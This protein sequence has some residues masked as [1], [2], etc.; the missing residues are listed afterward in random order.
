MANNA[1]IKVSEFKLKYD[2]H[3]KSGDSVYFKEEDY[4]TPTKGGWHHSSFAEEL[5]IDGKTPADIPLITAT[6]TVDWGAK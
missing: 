1:N 5:C 6:Y 4:H 2:R 3:S